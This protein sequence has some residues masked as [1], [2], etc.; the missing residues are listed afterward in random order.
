MESYTNDTAINI[1]DVWKRFKV[2]HEKHETLKETVL[3]FRRAS[4]EE[5]WALKGV[6]LGIKRGQTFGI[7]GENGSG[8]STLLKAIARI[9]RADRGEINVSGRMSALLELGA[10][11]HLDLT[12]RENI[13]LNGAI[14]QLTR[15]EI[16]QK[17]DDIVSFSELGDFIDTAVRNYSSGMYMRLGFSI[18]V[19][20]DPDILLIDEVLAV[21]DEAFQRKC[22][23]RLFE[24]KKAKKTIV[25]VSHDLS[26][27]ARF[28]DAA[29]WLE[30]GEIK[31]EGKARDVAN[32][33]LLS[34]TR[35]D[36]AI[37]HSERRW[38]SREIEV[39]GVE[40]FDDRG[41]KRRV[42]TMNRKFIARINY[43]SHKPIENP[44]FG[45]AVYAGDGSLITGPNTK[46]DK[47]IPSSVNGSGTVDFVIESLP[48]LPGK[49][50]FSA[51]I[52]DYACRHAYDHH[53]Q[54]YEF[55]VV[56]AEDDNT[57]GAVKISSQWN[58]QGGE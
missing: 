30:K 9:L 41:D 42:F 4:Y 12:G 20:V 40:F 31:A 55:E 23:D 47:V 28:C 36:Q 45:V 46:G 15:R 8:K 35:S 18:A 24:L 22:F 29:C 7:I 57:A 11:F 52:Y 50:R 32:L 17:F 10:G 44:V 5:F 16:D 37:A 43:Q 38:G 3:S 49:Y 6:T 27:I 39:T 13:Y 1:R 26:A 21:G 51:A 33:Y 34:T 19:S 53:E 58:F 56:S 14:L 25:I 2:Y 54:M 48:L